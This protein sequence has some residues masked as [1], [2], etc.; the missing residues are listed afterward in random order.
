MGR[1][2]R[3]FQ[4]NAVLQSAIYFGL[5]AIERLARVRMNSRTEKYYK[6]I[7]KNLRKAQAAWEQ[8]RRQ[9]PY[10]YS[11]IACNVSSMPVKRG[12]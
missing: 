9:D 4:P 1:K 3:T 12:D 11:A 10:D 6:S 2:S 7:Q 8:T 5:V